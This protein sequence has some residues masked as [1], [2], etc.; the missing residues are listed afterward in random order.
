MKIYLFKTYMYS[1]MVYKRLF[2]THVYIPGFNTVE[3]ILHCPFLSI[4]NHLRERVIDGMRF[5]HTHTEK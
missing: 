5:L 3:K 1:K 4:G 2:Y